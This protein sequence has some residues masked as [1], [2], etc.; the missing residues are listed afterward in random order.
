PR[1]QLHARCLSRARP[2]RREGGDALRRH[3]PA[4]RR[5]GPRAAEEERQGGVL[6]TARRLGG[7]RPRHGGG[8]CPL[9]HDSRRGV[10]R[11]DGAAGGG[12]RGEPGRA[13]PPLGRV[14]RGAP[15]ARRRRREGAGAQG[16]GAR[17]VRKV[18]G[19]IDHLLPLVLPQATV[20]IV[21][22]VADAAVGDPVYGWH[23]VRLV[24]RTLTWIEERLR[25]AG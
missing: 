3:R 9:R 8:S 19:W 5:S 17:V 25:A 14:P 16:A 12:A 18:A 2:V 11:R 22:A 23:P 20:L 6:R 13:G 15:A 1:G 4:A 21:A 10:R 24:G 7:A